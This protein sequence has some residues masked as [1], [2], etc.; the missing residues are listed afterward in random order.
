MIPLN[1]NPRLLASTRQTIRRNRFD[2][3]LVYACNFHVCLIL[4]LLYKGPQTKTFVR[5]M[6]RIGL[7]AK[8][9]A[10][11][12]EE[13]WMI[14]WDLVPSSKQYFV[15][16]NEISFSTRSRFHNE[17]SFSTRS[18]FLRYR[19][20]RDLVYTSIARS[21]SLENNTFSKSRKQ[22]RDLA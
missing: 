7:L 2:Y 17:I 11:G 20:S 16:E 1:W 15:C 21:R 8:I 19:F 14:W 3:F 5:W 22:S 12:T 4:T 18:C 6:K 13:N 10:F 9:A